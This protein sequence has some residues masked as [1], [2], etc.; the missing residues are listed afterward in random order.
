MYHPS[1]VAPAT[2]GPYNFR[3]RDQ[4]P[5]P[6]RLLHAPSVHSPIDLTG[7]P[8]SGFDQNGR[9]QPFSTDLEVNLP[10]CS[11]WSGSTRPRN[12][13]NRTS[14][15]VIIDM[16]AVDQTGPSQKVHFPKLVDSAISSSGNR[17][18]CPL[19][20]SGTRPKN[21]VKPPRMSVDYGH[22]YTTQQATT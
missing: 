7:V 15:S 11:H 8:C 22:D 17:L 18:A 5:V 2:N 19:S 20:F 3:A 21:T 1:S 4:I 9:F 6:Q 13:H 10:G 14:D 16:S 12:V